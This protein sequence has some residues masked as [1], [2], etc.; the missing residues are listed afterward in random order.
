MSRISIWEFLSIR[1]QEDSLIELLAMFTLLPIGGLV[2]YIC[3][4]WSYYTYFL[5]MGLVLYF[6][7]LKWKESPHLFEFVYVVSFLIINF[8][9][10]GY[11]LVP[12]V[13]SLYFNQRLRWWESQP[14]YL[15]GLEGEILKGEDE[16][17]HCK[18]ENI[19]ANGASIRANQDYEGGEKITLCFTYEGYTFSIESE[20][21][22]VQ[23]S[24]M[25]VQFLHNEETKKQVQDVIQ[26]SFSKKFLERNYAPPLLES[27]FLWLH[28]LLKTGKG[29]FPE[30][31]LV[32]LSKKKKLKKIVSKT[33]KKTKTTKKMK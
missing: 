12:A 17:L 2:I 7:Y 15:V 14:R 25:G 27:F 21:K 19:S 31:S 11:F 24:L 1:W 4:K 3:K 26:T 9:V 33:K 23:G 28:R 32:E 20:I 10:V 29:I 13:R 8:F 5:I 30:K 18:M 22:Y 6:N 16:A